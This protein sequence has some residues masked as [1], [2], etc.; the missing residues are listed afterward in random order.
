MKTRPAPRRAPEQLL[1]RLLC[2][3]D[4]SSHSQTALRYAIELSGRTGATLFVLHVSDPLLDA[5]AAAAAYNTR[6]LQRRA[7]VE[8]RRFATRAGAK[9]LP[10]FVQASGHPAPTIHREAERLEVDAIVMGSRGLTGPTKMFFGSTAERT[11]RDASVPVLVVPKVLPG[12]RQ[13]RAQLTA[14]PGDLAL[15]PVD[16]ADYRVDD[17][18]QAMRFVAALGAAPQFLYVLPPV[19][20]PSWLGIPRLVADTPSLEA[21]W[22]RFRK[23]VGGAARE[24]EC[25]VAEGDPAERITAT[26]VRAGAGVIALPLRR[27]KT[28]LGPRRG[29]VSYQIVA[30]DVLPVLAIVTG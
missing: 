29:S 21:A 2:P 11:L 24:A 27:G 19:R 12:R 17:V 18:R 16:L 25:R 10:E 15:I 1:K 3:I 28:L 22:A 4:F 30:K 7:L 23:A 20:L 6:E 8:M 5:A 26:A 13:A 9:S 14:W